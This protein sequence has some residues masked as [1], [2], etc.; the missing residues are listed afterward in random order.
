MQ[1]IEESDDDTDCKTSTTSTQYQSGL[2][3]GFYIC[4]QNAIHACMV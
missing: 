4:T 2:N 3:Q 1:D